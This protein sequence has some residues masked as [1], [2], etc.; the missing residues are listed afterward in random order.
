MIKNSL[1]FRNNILADFVKSLKL[2]TFND[3]YDSETFDAAFGQ[4]NSNIF[5]V[6]ERVFFLNWFY[7]NLDNLFKAYSILSNESSR[8][9]YKRLICFRLAGHHSY[10]ID[11]P[12]SKRINELDKY[13]AIV[14]SS[15]SKL[16]IGGMFGK[17]RHYDF[18]YLNKRYIVDC[19]GLD[20]Y[21]HRHQYFYDQEDIKIMP[22]DGDF[23]IDGGA[24]LGDSTA[25]FSNAVGNHGKVF[26]FDP[27]ADHLDIL[28]YNANQFP[29]NN[30]EVIDYGLSNKNEYHEPFKLNQ[31]NPGFQANASGLPMVKID[32]LVA[33]DIIDKIDFI[34]LDVEGSEVDALL[35]AQR[36]ISIF[37][38]KMAI[39]VYHKPD[40]LFEIPL[41]ISK[42]FPFYSKITLD[43]YSIQ[44]GE[45]VLYVSM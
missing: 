10:R 43:H 32:S 39:S 31:Y 14:K 11:A 18:E 37:Q 12:Y 16:S 4:D 35:G 21:L 23:L 25:V 28:R 40:D 45:S 7:L 24:C 29:I 27:V 41:L 38:P 17:L 8:E 1:D 33:N 9:I 19:L 6:G 36:S 2:N 34:K 5:Q 42:I 44:M 13:L 20:Y 22:E 26:A 30:V 15:D 3:N